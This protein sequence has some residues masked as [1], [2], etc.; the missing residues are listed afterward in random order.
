MGFHPSFSRVCAL[1][2]GMSHPTN[3]P[4][5]PKC[6]AASSGVSETTGTFRPRPMTSAMSRAALPLRRLHDTGR[7]CVCLLQRQ[8]V[9]PGS[10]EAVSRGPAVEPVADVRRNTLFARDLDRIGNETLLHGVVDLREAAPSQRGRLEPRP[11][12]PPL[13]KLREESLSN[14]P[15][16]RLRWRGMA[17]R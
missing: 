17:W 12:R 14:W 6:S 9:Q 8:P 2:A 16:D 4:S 15:A 13:P 1:E 10:I 3:A 11:Q 5:Q 7:S